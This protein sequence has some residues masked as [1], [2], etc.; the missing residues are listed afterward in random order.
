M[1]KKTTPKHIIFKLQ[2]RKDEGKNL[3]KKSEG[4]KHLTYR[5]V[6]NYILRNHASKSG[7]KYSEC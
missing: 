7:V 5:A 4:K 3:P 2:K 1:S 6:K